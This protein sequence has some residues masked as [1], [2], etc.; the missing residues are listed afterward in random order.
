MLEETTLKSDGVVRSW[1]YI[2]EGSHS[3]Y[4]WKRPRNLTL[5]NSSKCPARLI[6]EFLNID[7]NLR[8]TY[9]LVNSGPGTPPRM[10]LGTKSFTY[11]YALI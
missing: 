8:G 7:R 1:H 4:F 9:G 2:Q 10:G 6:L 3:A 11:L 5:V